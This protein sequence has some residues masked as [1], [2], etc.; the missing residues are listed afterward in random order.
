VAAL[1]AGL[2]DQLIGRL[3]RSAA[4]VTATLTDTRES[5]LQLVVVAN[6][7]GTAT[8]TVT[9]SGAL[10]C[11]TAATIGST[12]TVAAQCGSVQASVQVVNQGNGSISGTLT[13]Q[14]LSA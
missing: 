1:P 9:R 11:Q 7:D 14:K 8:L 10:V 5:A 2:N 4:N 3:V 12:G 13:T 6:P